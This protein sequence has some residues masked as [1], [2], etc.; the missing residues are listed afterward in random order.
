[1]RPGLY[2]Q[3][4]W[5]I[6]SPTLMASIII[7]STYFMLSNTPTYTAWNRNLVLSFETVLS[8][9]FSQLQAT[10]E[11]KEYPTWALCLATMLAMSSLIPEFLNVKFFAQADLCWQILRKVLTTQFVQ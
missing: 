10:G 5:R 4:M 3:L 8:H 7:S 11:E 1:M 6:I 2:W 9:I